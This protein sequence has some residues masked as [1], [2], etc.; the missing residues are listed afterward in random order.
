M[1]AFIPDTLLVWQTQPAPRRSGGLTALISALT[2]PFLLR[3]PCLHNRLSCMSMMA[4]TSASPPSTTTTLM[5]LCHHHGAPCAAAPSTRQPDR[6]YVDLG[7]LSARLLRPQLL[8]PDTLVT[9]TSA[10]RATALHEDWLSSLATTYARIDFMT[11]GDVRLS[12]SSLV[13]P[14][15]TLLLCLRGDVRACEVLVLC[16]LYNQP[17]RP[18]AIHPISSIL[19]S[20]SY[21]HRMCPCH[22]FHQL[23][24]PHMPKKP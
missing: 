19:F 13:S 24:C 23:S 2:L 20:F 12:T 17:M 5:C 22:L 6:N 10:Q 18:N 11:M 14:S 21:Y 7:H 3:M 16:T 4:L 9:S 15:A 8:H 1:C